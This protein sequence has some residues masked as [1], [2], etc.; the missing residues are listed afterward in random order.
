MWTR[1]AKK[2]PTDKIT[3]TCTDWNGAVF[4]TGEFDTVQEAD[5][6]GENAERRMTLRMQMGG[7]VECNLT[8]D[9][10][11]AELEE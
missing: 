7:L 10:I 2:Q 8:I 11:L 9:E 3:V 1:S 5:A 4:F 6:A